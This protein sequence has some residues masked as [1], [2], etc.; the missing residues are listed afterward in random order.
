MVVSDI[1]APFNSLALGLF[2]NDDLIG[3]SLGR[4]M[5]FYDGTQYRIDEFCIKTNYQGNG[6]GSNFFNLMNSY[7]KRN[8]ISTIILTT[9]RNYPAYSFY[10][11]NKFMGAKSNVMFFKYVG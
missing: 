9:E 2:L 4:I 5:H 3:I 1:A 10:L 8:G 6:F 11:K 7:L